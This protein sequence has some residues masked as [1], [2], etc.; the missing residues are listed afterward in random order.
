[1][2]EFLD[3]RAADLVAT[4]LLVLGVV[5]GRAAA[6]RYIRSQEWD[7]VQLSRRWLVTIRNVALLVLLFGIVV[8]WAEQLRTAAIS[9]LALGAAI[10]IATKELIMCVSGSI[11]R[12]SGR[13]FSIGDRIEIRGMRGD[14]VDHS[15][16]VTTILEVGPG[17]ARTGRTI[18]FPNSLLVTDSVVNETA[19]RDFV[20]HAFTVPVDRGEWREAA[21]QLL[22]AAEDTVESFVEQAAASFEERARRYSLALPSVRPQVVV[23]VSSPTTV[24]LTVRVPAPVNGKGRI[25]QEVILRWLRESTDTDLD[26]SD[27]TG[28]LPRVNRSET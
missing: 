12:A 6:V 18:V 13:S 23:D 10:V 4:A 27:S 24:E 7:N 5:V 26:E 17:E 20:L 14:V 9:L 28:M 22:S 21:D 1:M 19:G 15:L 3:S 16:L 8:I 11:V 25:E 2:E